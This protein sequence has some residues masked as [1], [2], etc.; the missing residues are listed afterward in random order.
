MPGRLGVILELDGSRYV[1]P[2]EV[3]ARVVRMAEVTRVPD[4]P[5]HVLGV[6]DV[7]GEVLPVLD[8][9]LR[10]GHPRKEPGVDHRLV[11]VTLGEAPFVVP[12]DRV[13]GPVDLSGGVPPPDPVPASDPVREVL[14]DDAGLLMV[15]EPGRLDLQRWRPPEKPD[16]NGPA[17]KPA[18]RRRSSRAKKKSEAGGGG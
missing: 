8:L 17:A 16:R 11:V 13:D 4:A 6:L 12:A 18:A 3:V 1:L 9:R 5:E 14:A 2:V 7:A 10:L 15:L